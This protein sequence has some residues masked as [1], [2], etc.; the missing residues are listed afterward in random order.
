MWACNSK[1]SQSNFAFA[2]QYNIGSKIGQ[3]QLRSV[4]FR[5]SA[6]LCEKWICVVTAALSEDV[7]LEHLDFIVTSCA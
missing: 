3:V 7:L 2:I 1:D 4:V 6:A 5:V